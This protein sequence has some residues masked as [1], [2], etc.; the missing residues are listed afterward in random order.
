M[1]TRID[2]KSDELPIEIKDNLYEVKP[3]SNV[4]VNVNFSGIIKTSSCFF[5]SF[6]SDKILI[7]CTIKNIEDVNVSNGFE[8]L[9]KTD[10]ITLLYTYLEADNFLQ[11]NSK[12]S[13]HSNIIK[14]SDKNKITCASNSNG[15]TIVFGLIL[16]F[17][18]IPAI[19]FILSKFI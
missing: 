3:N 6:Y 13:G 7:D 19:I 12:I 16:L 5:P 15:L 10:K 4:D 1:I 11:T 17:T 18:I 9:N 8:Y 2:R 14:E